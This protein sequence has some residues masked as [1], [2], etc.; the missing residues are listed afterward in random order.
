MGYHVEEQCKI[1]LVALFNE[2]NDLKN[3]VDEQSSTTIIKYHVE[4]LHQLATE[5]KQEYE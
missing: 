1:K 3:L 2:I 4:S 5:L